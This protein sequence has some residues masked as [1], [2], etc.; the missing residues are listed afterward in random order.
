MIELKTNYSSTSQF[1]GAQNACR[2][3]VFP[4]CHSLSYEMARHYLRYY[5][6]GEWSNSFCKLEKEKF[7]IDC[8][9]KVVAFGS[10]QDI[11][12][13]YFSSQG[14]QF[15]YPGVSAVFEL[16]G[17]GWDYIFEATGSDL[18]R[19]MYFISTTENSGI[20]EFHL[21]G[22]RDGVVRISMIFE[23]K[24]HFNRYLLSHQVVCEDDYFCL[25]RNLHE[26]KA[27]FH[28]V[29]THNKIPDGEL[30]QMKEI[31]EKGSCELLPREQHLESR[32]GRNVYPDL[33]SGD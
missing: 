27:L 10:P 32:H 12:M 11:Y 1:L 6:I 7:C 16:K 23:K 19:Q 30:K 29:S 13:R 22:Y 8:N 26:L 17:K 3:F 31:V 14:S 28:I 4:C 33:Y 21:L 18:C 15:F 5:P 20:K 2:G 24:S 25:S 9:E